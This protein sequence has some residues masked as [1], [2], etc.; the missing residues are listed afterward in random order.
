M[1]GQRVRDGARPGYAPGIAPTPTVFVIGA[2]AVGTALARQ[3]GRRGVPVLGV[4]ARRAEA[5][6]RGAAASGV[7]GSSGPLPASVRSAE[8][9]LVA[10]RDAEIAS[11]ARQLVDQGG[12][13]RHQVVLHTCGARP[14][15]ELLGALG[16]RVRG[17]GTMHPL[18]ALTATLPT[19]DPFVDVAFGVEGDDRATDMAGRL[20]LALGAHPLRLTAEGMALYHAGAVVASNYLVA[21]TD[22]A[23]ELLVAA[24]VDEEAAVPALVPLMRSALDNL[25][26]VGVTEALTGPIVRG[27]VAS[28]ER[29]LSALLACAPAAVAAYAHLGRIALRIASRRAAP[30]PGEA[31]ER[32]SAIFDGVLGTSAGRAPGR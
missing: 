8:V 11:V 25:Q 1:L 2:G 23:R 12:T 30:P 4:H 17:I 22:L 6:G 27:D 20:A 15:Q 18:V 19:L 24:G 28:V 16:G 26:E 9:V 10:V 31:L 32:L 13:S 7:L 14:A 3:L 21:L 29:H 5:A